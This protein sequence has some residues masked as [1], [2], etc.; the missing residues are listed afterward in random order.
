M[1]EISLMLLALLIEGLVVAVV[2]L[3]VMTVIGLRRNSRDRHAV[4]TLIEQVRHQ[5]QT[6]METT[7]S[8]LSEKY[9]FEGDELDKAVKAIDKSE[10]K[11]MQSF[12]NVYLKRDSEKLVSLDA[13]LA[14]LIDVYKSLSPAT[15]PAES[16]VDDD[17]IAELEELRVLN[18]GLK[19]ELNITKE[20]MA[21]MISEFGN[22][23]GG[24]SNHELGKHEVI[25]KVEKKKSTAETSSADQEKG[26]SVPATEEASSVLDDDIVVSTNELDIEPELESESPEVADDDVLAD[27]GVEELLNGIDLASDK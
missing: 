14:E 2:L 15:P 5:S 10:K 24:G 12:A 7:G 19:E 22:M 16:V 25:E 4:E 1:I 23:F 21:N 27:E 17:T 9:S 6:R 8:F 20:T 18:A 3:I 13:S 26:D 11:F